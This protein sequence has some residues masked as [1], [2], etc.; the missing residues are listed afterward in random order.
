MERDIKNIRTSTVRK[1][2]WLTKILRS[3]MYSNDV[4]NIQN[5]NGKP[6]SRQNKISQNLPLVKLHAFLDTQIQLY[7]RNYLCTSASLI[8]QHSFY[9]SEVKG[10]SVRYFTN[11]PWQKN[12]KPRVQIM[13]NKDSKVFCCSQTLGVSYPYEIFMCIFQR[14]GEEF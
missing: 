8:V 14:K 7:P 5:W 11:E 3:L 1:H 6:Y 2:M 9:V 4:N 10:H 12:Y 13:I